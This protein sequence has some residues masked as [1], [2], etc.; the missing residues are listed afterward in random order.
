MV[1][2]Y[3][4]APCFGAGDT[5]AN[6]EL[7]IRHTTRNFRKKRSS[8]CDFLTE[9]GLTA[10]YDSAVKITLGTGKLSCDERRVLADGCLINFYK[11]DNSLR[12][13]R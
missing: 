1:K 6:G 10:V 11:S 5:P 7:S 2:L 12:N 9:S 8:G 13:T 4:T 3:D